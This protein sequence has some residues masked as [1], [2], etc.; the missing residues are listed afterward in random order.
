MSKNLLSVCICSVLWVSRVGGQVSD[1]PSWI[2]SAHFTVSL[3]VNDTD[4]GVRHPIYGGG[5]V[6]WETLSGT[7]SQGIHAQGGIELRRG[8]LGFRGTLGVL[9][10]ELT[11][12]APA[13]KEGFSLLLGGFSVVL[14]PRGGSPV[15]VQPYLQGG[16]GGQK[17]MGDLDN[18]GFFLSGAAG[19]VTSL[20]GR[21][22]LDGGVQVLRLKYTQVDLG[23][24]I[25]KDLTAHPVSLFL[26]VRLRVKGGPP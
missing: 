12:E 21:V 20:T 10:Q 14:Y 24:N 1:E 8:K 17:A 19:V 18:T 16:A 5:N 11:E 23:N 15:R 3:A 26:G 2:W 4:W 25:Q 7:I 6:T 9:P 13:R 22:S